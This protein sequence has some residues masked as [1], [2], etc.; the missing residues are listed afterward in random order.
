MYIYKQYT[1]C[2]LLQNISTGLKLFWDHFP[3][4]QNSEWDLDPPTH[5]QSKLGFFE[6]FSLQS[7]LGDQ[8]SATNWDMIVEAMST[9]LALISP[10][11]DLPKDS[12]PF[13]PG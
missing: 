11:T 10:A 8:V 7:P 13:S 1:H 12:D 5:F 6:F 9:N 3:K 4:K 2:I